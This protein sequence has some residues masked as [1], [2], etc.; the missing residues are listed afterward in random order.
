MKT[1]LERSPAILSVALGVI[2][3]FSFGVLFYLFGLAIGIFAFIELRRSQKKQYRM[4]EVAFIGILLNS[5]L[6]LVDLLYH[7]WVVPRR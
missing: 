5:F 7:L 6:I 3:L 1:M 2:G 4:Q